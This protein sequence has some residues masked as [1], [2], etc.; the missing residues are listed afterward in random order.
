MQM[1]PPLYVDMD[2][3]FY[4]VAGTIHTVV[5]AQVG[6]VKLNYLK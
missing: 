4:I 6:I 1:P 3:S 2:I 5:A